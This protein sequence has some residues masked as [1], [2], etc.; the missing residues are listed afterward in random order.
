MRDSD[1]LPQEANIDLVELQRAVLEDS[2]IS[3]ILFAESW[4]VG[5]NH[6]VAVGMLRL[7][8]LPACPQDT[9]HVDKIGIRRKEL[10]EGMQIVADP[11]MKARESDLPFDGKR[12]I[13]G[14][15]EAF[16]GL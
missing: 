11:R 3:A 10:T 13:F 1:F 6:P 9:C 2:V 5:R 16:L 7:Y 12:V 14:G 4:R 15:F 8:G